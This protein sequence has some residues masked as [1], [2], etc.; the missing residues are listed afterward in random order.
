MLTGYIRACLLGERA[1]KGPCWAYTVKN[2]LVFKLSS[3][4]DNL[5]NCS[6][7]IVCMGLRITFYDT[8]SSADQ[9]DAYNSFFFS[10]WENE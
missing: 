1:R 4:N 2:K 5:C 7:S 10:L 8:G 6:L 9:H 3:T